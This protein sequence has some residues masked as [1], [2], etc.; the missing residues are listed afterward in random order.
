M[1]FYDVDLKLL[2]VWNLTL[3]AFKLCLYP[4]TEH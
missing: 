4:E 3:N 2:A 1:R